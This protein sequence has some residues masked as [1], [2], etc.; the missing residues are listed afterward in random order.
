MSLRT[1]ERKRREGGREGE[2]GREASRQAEAVHLGLEATV[3]TGF[4]FECT[5][6]EAASTVPAEPATTTERL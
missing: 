3:K 6:T 5:G 2:E 4:D 1:S